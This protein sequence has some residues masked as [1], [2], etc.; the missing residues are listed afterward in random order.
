[1]SASASVVG[2]E[3]K[4][5]FPHIVG[6]Q[7]IEIVAIGG[8]RRQRGPIARIF[9]PPDESVIAA[10]LERPWDRLALPDILAVGVGGGRQRRLDEKRRKAKLDAVFF[11]EFFL[12]AGTQI[13]NG[14]HAGFI[15]RG[16]NRVFGLGLQQTL[17]RKSTRLNS[18]H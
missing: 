2:L 9:D 18:S 15:E 10:T 4:I 6:A 1:M 8:E 7:R 5:R 11:F 12:V 16:E 17:D 3:G 14:L 13:E